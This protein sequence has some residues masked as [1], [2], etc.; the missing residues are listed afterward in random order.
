MKADVLKDRI[1]SLTGFIGFDYMNQP[2]GIDPINHSQYEMWYG[3]KYFVAKS[4][5]EVM[6]VQLFDGKSLNQICDNIQNIDF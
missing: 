1:D 4:I 2:C 6:S 3:K 5:D